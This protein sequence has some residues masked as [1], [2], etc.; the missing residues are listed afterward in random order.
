MAKAALAEAH[1]K[2]EEAKFMSSFKAQEAQTSV[3]RG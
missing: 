3:R 1:E 2:I